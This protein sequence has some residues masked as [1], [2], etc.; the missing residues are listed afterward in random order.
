MNNT[1]NT[2]DMYAEIRKN[3]NKSL[4]F[5]IIIIAVYFVYSMFFQD[6]ACGGVTTTGRVR[7]DRD[8]CS[9]T[10]FVHGK[11]EYTSSDLLKENM[12]DFYD[13]SGVQPVLYDL[14]GKKEYSREEIQKFADDFYAE[15][16]FPDPDTG[17][18]YDEGHFLIVFQAQKNGY[19]TGYHIGTDAAT[20]ID[21]AAL[22]TFD[23][24]LSTEYN[25]QKDASDLF[26]KV[27]KKA[28]V[29]IMGRPKSSVYLIA[30]IMAALVLYLFYNG[31]KTFKN[32]PLNS[33][34]GG[35]DQ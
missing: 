16:M 35:T 20:V 13:A 5:F 26:G 23:N 1:D 15:K 7:L 24:I 34:N 21:K 33:S 4:I 10:N 9:I 12:I 27:F 2:D 32:K 22:T 29:E 19:L 6:S 11:S 8:K 14:T 17:A 31:W 18:V 28:G 3:R 30:G 25:K